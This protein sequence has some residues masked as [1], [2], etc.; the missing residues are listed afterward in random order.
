MF[1]F[2][3]DD[4]A[5][6]YRVNHIDFIGFLW[7]YFLGFFFISFV[8]V[9]FVL[10]V[11]FL[12]CSFVHIFKPSATK[13]LLIFNHGLTSLVGFFVLLNDELVV[14]LLSVPRQDWFLWKYLLYGLFIQFGLKQ[15]KNVI[16]V[17][18]L[19]IWK[20]SYNILIRLYLKSTFEKYLI[21]CLRIGFHISLYILIYFLI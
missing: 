8:S 18:F 13:H 16:V 2:S 21:L 14:L 20:A 19:K 1:T 7:L 10:S 17:H 9:S 3:S 4:V 6:D 15:C 5:L 11:L 12:F